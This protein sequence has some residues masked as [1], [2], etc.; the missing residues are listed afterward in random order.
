MLG[1]S[2][3]PRCAGAHRRGALASVYAS[4]AQASKSVLH[5]P[6]RSVVLHAAQSV[7]VPSP[8]QVNWQAP[9]AIP[10]VL[11]TQSFWALNKSLEPAHQ[12][13]KSES[14]QNAG[15]AAASQSVTNCAHVTQV[16]S[17]P[18]PPVP[19][20]LPL[21]PV[22]VVL[23]PVL[24]VVVVVS[25]PVPAPPVPVAADVFDVSSELQPSAPDTNAPAATAAIS[26]G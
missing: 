5:A 9:P 26:S 15:G 18:P 19:P 6:V 23:P 21:P 8:E 24:V 25:P 3:P 14:A 1:I 12:G 22:L 17:P 2:Y 7:S 11:Q 13:A 10:H 16:A 4:P 20:P